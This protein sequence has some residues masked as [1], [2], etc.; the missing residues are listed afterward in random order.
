[1]L[2][3]GSAR[4]RSFAGMSRFQ[5]STRAMFAYDKLILLSTFS[6][7]ERGSPI[8]HFASIIK[9]APPAR[10]PAAP[11]TPIRQ[12]EFHHGTPYRY[13]FPSEIPTFRLVFVAPVLY[14]P[15]AA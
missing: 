6:A 11:E 12:Q 14:R 13:D 4:I 3:A 15:Q 10:M 5:A 9:R 2:P 1:M 7:V 8:L